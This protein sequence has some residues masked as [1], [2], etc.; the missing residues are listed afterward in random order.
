MQTAKLHQILKM[1][2]FSLQNTDILNTAVL[3]GKMVS[4]PVKI[5]AVKAD[6]SVT[7]VTNATRCRS[8]E[9]DVLKVDPA[10]EGQLRSSWLPVL[11]DEHL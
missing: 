9:E 4:V 1:F 3:T 7:D 5:L 2:M 10:H 11:C 6:G 8:T